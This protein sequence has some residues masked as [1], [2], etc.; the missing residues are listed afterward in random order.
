VK[1]CECGAGVETWHH[2]LLCDRCLGARNW[3]AL[4]GDDYILIR[5]MR[6]GMGDVWLSSGQDGD[7]R[8]TNLTALKLDPLGEAARRIAEVLDA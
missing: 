4:E 8:S 1:C 2:V 3:F 7:F 6:G 5:R